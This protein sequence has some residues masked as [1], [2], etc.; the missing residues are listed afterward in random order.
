[1][2]WKRIPLSDHGRGEAG[3][4]QD[5]T[6]KSSTLALLLLIV[7]KLGLGKDF[8]PLWFIQKREG[9]GPSAGGGEG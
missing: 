9:G 8:P 3:M 1:M 6:L 5:R 2:I 4:L 7:G